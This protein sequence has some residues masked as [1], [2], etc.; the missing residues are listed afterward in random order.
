MQK[1]LQEIM[2]SDVAT[3][4]QNDDVYRAATIM[5]DRNVG[6]VPVVDGNQH[7]I[8]IV[9]D[10]DIV[11]RGIA[12]RK[13]GS[14]KVDEVMSHDVILGRPDMTVDDA[15]RIMADQQIRRLPVVEN[16]RLVGIVAMADMAVRR[17]FADEA[18]QALSE[19][20]EPTG[21][22]SQGQQPLQ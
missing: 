10:R 15:S 3:C 12:E 14:A 1:T 19:I 4:S 11:V 16:G 8:G 7:C 13:D 17:D 21:Q 9:T 18:G 6:V 2:T 5:R 20:S 22:H